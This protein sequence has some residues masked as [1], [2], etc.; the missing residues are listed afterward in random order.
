MPKKGNGIYRRK[1]GRYEAIHYYGIN[2]ATGRP[3]KLTRYGKTAKEAKEKLR[4]AVSELTTG[5]MLDSTNMTLEQWLNKWLEVYSKPNT[6]QSTFISYEGYVRGHI[7]P[8]IGKLKLTQLNAEILQDFFNSEYENGRLDGKGGVSE[9]TLRNMRNMFHCALQQAYDN[10][11]IQKNYVEQVKMPKVPQKEMRVLDDYEQFQLC[12][13]LNKTE[14][15]FGIGVYLALHTGMR[16]GEICGLHWND[17]DISSCG[18]VVRVR[19]TLGRLMKYPDKSGKLKEGEAST[20]IVETLPKS[21]KSIRDIPID[22]SVCKVLHEYRN[23]IFTERAKCAEVYD[24]TGYVVCTEIG[25]H[26]EPKTLSD[27]YGRILKD[28]GIKDANFHS[29]R[30]T[31]ATNAIKLGI[32]P[33]TVSELLGHADVSVTLN[34]YAHSFDEQKRQAM[35]KIAEHLNP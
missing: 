34:R 26:I 2:P 32:D 8:K 28:A 12:A 27:T 30:H 35:K 4:L 20:E 23:K 3:K 15:R 22:E 1:D 31:F 5:T 25:T 9:K 6:K 11:L 13:E 21:Q 33:K 14:E 19:R 29:L 18:G 7:V 24:K 16:I 10:N 17:V